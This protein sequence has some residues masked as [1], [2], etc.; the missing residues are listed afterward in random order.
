VRCQDLCQDLTRLARSA[1]TDPGVV[2]NLFVTGTRD[3]ENAHDHE[4]SRDQVTPTSHV[5]V[6]THTI[7]HMT[8]GPLG[9]HVT[10]HM[11]H[12]VIQLA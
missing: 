11:T 10:Y 1:A 5:T 8:S 2:T 12:H 4:N 3:R 6:G 7:Y 9:Y